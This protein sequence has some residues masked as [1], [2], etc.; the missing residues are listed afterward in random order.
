MCKY[1]YKVHGK[2]ESGKEILHK[3]IRR[4]NVKE[5]SKAD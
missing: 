2:R 1:K 3:E 5:K 4:V